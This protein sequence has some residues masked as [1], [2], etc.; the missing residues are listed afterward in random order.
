LPS[1]TRA[2]RGSNDNVLV[3]AQGKTLAGMAARVFM[4]TRD[5]G[6]GRG[7][8]GASYVWNAGTIDGVPAFLLHTSHSVCHLCLT[9]CQI[10]DAP[11][12]RTTATNA[13]IS[14]LVV[15]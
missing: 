7:N 10:N 8:L 13:L 9:E 15:A 12:S 3:F 6:E 4:G 1:G 11:V 5:P 14:S 2:S